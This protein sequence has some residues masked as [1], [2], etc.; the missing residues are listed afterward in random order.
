MEIY[1]MTEKNLKQIWNKNNDIGKEVD[2]YTHGRY[3]YD[4]DKGWHLKES[5]EKAVKT[6]LKEYLNKK[7]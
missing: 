2:N 7:K 3:A 6:V 5:V 1:L 4:N